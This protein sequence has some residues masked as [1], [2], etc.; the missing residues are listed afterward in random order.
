VSLKGAIAANRFGLGAR[1]GEIDEAS[2][3]PES[4]LLRQLETRE[5][6][7]RLAGL[8]EGATIAEEVTE[9][10]RERRSLRRQMQNGGQNPQL[11][12]Q[13][14]RNVM[15]NARQSYV[16]EIAA[17]FSH[18]VETSQPFRERLVR[19]WSNHFVVSMQNPRC[20]PFVGAFE[21]EAIRPHVTGKFADLVLAAER[22]P[23]MLLYLD[24]AQ[25]IGPNSMAGARRNRGLNENLS[26]EILELHTLGV[27]G[28]YSQED[29]AALAEII[30]GWSVD[31]GDFGPLRRILSPAA[32]ANAEGGFRFFPGLHEPG[33]KM[34]LGKRYPEGYEGGVL[35]LTDLAHHPATARHV[36][37]KLARHFVADAPTEASVT[38]IET[39]F[40]ASGG[41][42]KTIYAAIVSDPAAWVE[43]PRKFRT[44]VEYITAALRVVALGPPLDER[45]VQ[46]IVAAARM[47]GEIPL[48]APSPKGWPDVADAWTG[49]EA[50]VERVEWADAA[51]SRLVANADPVRLADA[52]LGPLLSAETR[53]AVTRAESPAQGLA[54][55]FAS[56]EFQRR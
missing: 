19:F 31:R 11:D 52:A 2:A 18:G 5:A 42:L 23:A 8:S 35:A 46:P 26:R 34:L 10:L 28:G 13:A 30:T 48:G 56:P 27:D 54:L 40:R 49:A 14:L 45:S 12:P 1:P 3:N 29:V 16:R 37:T 43:T 53:V 24:N 9:A 50:I 22:H 32:G 47:M 38:R 36:A 41:D 44:P 51:A 21:R 15:A 39:A 33:V 7:P 17:R 4:W 20:A 55:L 6:E 25:S